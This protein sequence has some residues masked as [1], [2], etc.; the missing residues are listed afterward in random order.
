MKKL[1]F[2]LLLMALSTVIYAQDI[3][4]GLTAGPNLSTARATYGDSQGDYDIEQPGYVIGFHI[5][6][7][8]EIEL[9]NRISLRPD[10]LYTQLGHKYAAEAD[11]D[12]FRLK[13][14][15]ITLPVIA[16]YAIG[17][18]LKAGLGPY[19][20]AKLIAK[21]KSI[22]SAD[23]DLEDYPDDWFDYYTLDKEEYK[24][25]DVGLE[26]GLGYW[27]QPR[28]GVNLRYSHGLANFWDHGGGGY[29]RSFRLG[30]SYT[31]R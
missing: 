2:T 7:F 16:E 10:L 28:I 9:T 29:N 25:F 17:E 31:I 23:A 20:A 13:S 5:G 6:G 14:G 18:K 3:R 15:Y 30:I 11:V 27:I 8:A 21:G 1:T 26:A 19:F 4:F 24:T 12:G 22:A